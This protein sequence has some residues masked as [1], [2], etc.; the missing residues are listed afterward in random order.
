MKKYIIGLIILYA[1]ICIP[2]IILGEVI[3]LLSKNIQN[4]ILGII[5][6]CATIGGILI[7][8]YSFMEK[9]R[10]LQRRI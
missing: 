8:Y 3:K 1:S 4:I 5:G 2:S 9:I 10:I 6:I 7:A